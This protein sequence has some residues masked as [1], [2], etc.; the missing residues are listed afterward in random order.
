MTVWSLPSAS[1]GPGV[2]VSSRHSLS[3]PPSVSPA[4][5]PGADRGARWSFLRIVDGS[6]AEVLS[7]VVALTGQHRHVASWPRAPQPR[8]GEVRLGTTAARCSIS[9]ALGYGRLTRVIPMVLEIAPWS[10]SSTLLELIPCRRIRPTRRY[11]RAGH[12]LLDALIDQTGRQR[13]SVGREKV[14]DLPG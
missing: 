8:L 10:E 3:S 1:E 2:L 5:M 6:Y 14:P 13:S 11:F 12:Q 7:V 9:L 4:D